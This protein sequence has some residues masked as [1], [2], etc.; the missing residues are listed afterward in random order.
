MRFQLPRAL[1]TLCPHERL[2]HF[3]HKVFVHEDRVGPQATHPKQTVAVVPVDL[4][5]A[6]TL[7]QPPNSWM[8]G[9]KRASGLAQF[10]RLPQIRG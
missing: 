2:L 10:R 1:R 8:P 6:E 3:V 7:S 4:R 9:G 5:C